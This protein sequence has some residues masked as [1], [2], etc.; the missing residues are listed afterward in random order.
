MRKQY[1]TLKHSRSSLER[2]RRAIESRI[3]EMGREEEKAIVTGALR[4]L[5]PC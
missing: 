1:K 3:I 5:L 2:K 4:R